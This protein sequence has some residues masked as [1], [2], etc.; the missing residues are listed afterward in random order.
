MSDACSAVPLVSIGVPVYNGEATLAAALESLVSQSSSDFEII[1]SDNASDD[2]TQEICREYEE[3]YDNIF[4]V[5]QDQN[6]GATNNFRFVLDRAR[7]QYFMWAAADDL[8]SPD[9]I[10]NNVL[11]LNDNSDYVASAGPNCF[12]GCELNKEQ[13]V[14]FLIKGDTPSD[15]FLEFFEYCWKS[16]GVFYSLIRTEIAKKCWFVGDSFIAADWAFNLFILTHGKFNRVDRGLTVLGVDG[17]SNQ[18]NAYRRFRNRKIEILFPFYQLSVYVFVWSK[19]FP[20]RARILLMSKLLKL[21]IQ[22]F[23]NQIYSDLYRFYCGVR[24]EIFSK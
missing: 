23:F 7:G 11:F 1:I 20:A 17:V 9:F 16:N 14:S 22:A 24:S 2:R 10:E 3:R 8:R 12:E 15:R 5:R 18:P 13:W 21:N 6:I 19:K 4:Y